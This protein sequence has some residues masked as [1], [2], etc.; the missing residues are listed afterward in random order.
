MCTYF[1]KRGYELQELHHAIKEVSQMDR[2]E[3]LDDKRKDKKDPQVI[4]VCDW[5]PIL[6]TVPSILKKH[7]HLLE[8]DT[9]TSK[10]FTSKPMVAFRRPRSIKNIVVKNDILPKEN[11]KPA[12]TTPCGKCSLC[13]NIWTTEIIRNNKK[14]IEVTIKDGGDCQTKG[15]IYAARCKKCDIICVGQT[16]KSTNKRFGG[17]RYDVK[18]RPDNTEL[19]TH[20]SCQHDFDK[21]MEVLILQ[22]GLNK[23][24]E[25]REFHEDRWICRLQTLQPSGINEEIHQ[26]AK[27][28]YQ[29]FSKLHSRNSSRN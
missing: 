2:S 1:V 19:A 27:E 20:F 21:D 10:V 8:N 25:E 23:S 14:N 4:F 15:V 3:L 24:Q 9:K 5:H 12:T 18:K 13:K 6:S 16:G 29:C 22:S 26:Y 11:D 28:M 17:H 7:F